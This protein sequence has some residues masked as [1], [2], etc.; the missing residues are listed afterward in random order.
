LGPASWSYY[1]IGV[2]PLGNGVSSSPS[3]SRTQPHMRFPAFSIRDMVASQHAMLTRVLHIPHLRAVMGR[4][5]N[6]YGAKL[7]A[8]REHPNMLQLGN[9]A[10]EQGVPTKKHFSSVKRSKTFSGGGACDCQARGN[11]QA[12]R[13][14]GTQR[15]ISKQ[16]G[17]VFRD[18]KVPREFAVHPVQKFS[19]G[20]IGSRL[21]GKS[22]VFQDRGIKLCGGIDPDSCLMVRPTVVIDPFQR[23]S[24]RSPLGAER[25]SS[26]T[27][28]SLKTSPAVK[29]I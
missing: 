24:S 22:G 25:T 18:V 19:C 11:V 21:C 13:E 27:I 29:I 26:T 1:V 5:I 10:Q 2:D 15:R 20:A 16:T 17:A 4:L 3:N 12:I 28:P 7:I 6:L 8:G 14:P 23:R 9:F